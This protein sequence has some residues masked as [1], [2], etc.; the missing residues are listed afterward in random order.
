MGRRKELKARRLKRE[1]R[2]RF[3]QKAAI[4]AGGIGLVIGAVKAVDLG[5][6]WHYSR[7][8]HPICE[9][10]LV[11]LERLALET[12]EGI[13]FSIRDSGDFSL[14]EY[15]LSFKSSLG[16]DFSYRKLL[17]KIKK[18]FPYDKHLVVA[19]IGGSYGKATQSLQDFEGVEAFVIDPH[20]RDGKKRTP[21]RIE[22]MPRN[23]FFVRKIENT[24]LPDG[25]FHF[26][27]SYN[28]YQY[29]KVPISFV[30]AYRLLKRGG[31]AVIDNIDWV[32]LDFWEKL[33]SSDIHRQVYV[34]SSPDLKRFD[35]L[36]SSVYHTLVKRAY[37]KQGMQAKEVL[38]ASFAP[39]FI[40]NKR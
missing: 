13:D 16:P 17:S 33:R 7:K 12:Q 38:R 1:A 40:M 6:V 9:R 21:T 5:I 28:T 34:A 2:R 35:L 27:T 26:L 32:N 10:E 36:P 31:E 4:G 8:R 19:D 30:E 37:D 22:T 25:T 14:S 20:I 15:E 3:L 18:R 39:S 29:T 23:R 11:E 24:G